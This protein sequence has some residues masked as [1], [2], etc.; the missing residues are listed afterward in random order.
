MTVSFKDY[1]YWSAETPDDIR[2]QLR[3]ICNERK[4]DI[5]QIGNLVNIFISGR[6]VARIPSGSADVIA[7]DK[8]N[9]INWDT[10][11]LYILVDN[12]GT[13]SWRRVALGSW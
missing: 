2:D 9:D 1:P 6:K 10:S 13:G 7:G 4:N 11:Y 5:T 3:Q 8:I 12:A